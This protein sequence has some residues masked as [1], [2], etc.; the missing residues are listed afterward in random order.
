MMGTSRA[1]SAARAYERRQSLQK[2]CPQPAKLCIAA[3]CCASKHIA[4][5]AGVSCA[6]SAPPGAAF[7]APLQCCKVCDLS[8]D[9]SLPGALIAALGMLAA[10]SS[11][12]VLTSGLIRRQPYHITHESVLFCIRWSDVK[13][14]RTKTCSGPA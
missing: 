12:E 4:H 14:A 2:R 9:G 10:A 7:G 8:S 11:A 1:E 3:A 13:P 5:V 6:C